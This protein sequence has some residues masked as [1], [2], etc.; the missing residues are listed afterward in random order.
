V[1][2]LAVT[3][4]DD[5]TDLPVPA[6]L[7]VGDDGGRFLLPAV[8]GD[9]SVALYDCTDAGTGIRETYAAVT[10]YPV[11]LELPPGRCA[12][13]IERGKEYLPLTEILDIPA[14]ASV[15]K[16]FR[17]RRLLSL[18]ERGWYSADCH[19]HTPLADLPAAQLADDVNVTFPI[20]AWATRSNQIPSAAPGRKVP[21][22]G[23][24]VRI[25][26]THV[27]WNLN[28]E[29]E[30]FHLGDR[31]FILGAF[32]IL[33]HQRPFTLTAPPVRPIAEEARGQGAI[34]DWEKHSWPWSNMLVPVAGIDTVELSNNSVW[35]QRTMSC[36]L[37]DRLPMP[38]VGTPPLNPE[39]F[40]HYGFE[41]WY[42]MLNCGFALRPSAGTANGVHPV[43][44]GHS[45]VY[46]HVDGPFTCEGWLAAW[47]Q[48]RSFATNG[49]MLL[50]TADGLEPGERRSIPP[51]ES[52]KI[53]V[54]IEAIS[55]GD[56]DRVELVVNGEVMKSFVVPP[57]S[58]RQRRH[59][60]A[61]DCTIEIDGTSWLATR[62]FEA[63]PTNNPRYAHTGPIFFDDPSRPLR[64]HRRQIDYLVG[65]LTRQFERVREVLAAPAL[66]EYTQALRAFESWL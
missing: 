32:M 2:R 37:W 10:R 5:A 3:V 63:T 14:D 22:R 43:P 9:R 30:I 13:T 16:T 56:L 59:R 60:A 20:T 11:E 45:R 62:C 17:I 47:R 66:D 28:T 44:L 40:M 15:E 24:L 46:A 7:Y 25:D 64:P 55:I 35:R 39:Q 33:G 42:A 61:F 21:D 52:V 12:V 57:A 31:P 6:R 1:S 27:Y 50:L 41:S 65:D 18:A 48:G 26:D 38:W 49:P 54:S 36:Y 29:Y 19:V 23:E 4:R 34:I 51:G 53:P 58:D 8:T